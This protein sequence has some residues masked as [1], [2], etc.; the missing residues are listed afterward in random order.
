MM[1]KTSKNIE[2]QR[3]EHKDIVYYDRGRITG[4]DGSK[5]DRFAI[6]THFINR[7]EDQFKIVEKY[8]LPL[9]IKGDILSFGAKVMSMC[10]DNV[11]TRDEVK[12]GFWA[13]ILWRFASSNQTGIGMHEPG[14]MQL[15]IDMVGLPRVLWAAFLSAITKPF[16]KKGVFYEVCGEGIG[17]IDG[18]YDRASF[19]IYKDLAV[20]NPPNP[21]QLSDELAEKFG[22]PVVIMD[23]ND[24]QRDQLGKSNNMPLSDEQIQY[25]LADNPSGQD[26]ELTPLIL[27]RPVI[28]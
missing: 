7:G 12:P 17:G 5:Y 22:I 24:I 19:E 1:N 18:F 13:N 4:D 10:I 14:K 16:G 25:A 23:A 20:I 3:R 28:D 8:F 26:D 6:Q 21:D 15:A 2:S 27:I 9:Y 11:K